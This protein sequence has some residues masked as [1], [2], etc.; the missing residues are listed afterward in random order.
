MKMLN[1]DK[2]ITGAVV[3]EL[4]LGGKSHPVHAMSVENFI[5]TSEA[6]DRVKDADLT[7]QVKET[8]KTIC[9]SVPSIDPAELGPLPIEKLQVVLAFVRGDE[10]EEIVG[11]GANGE[12]SGKE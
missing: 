2:V 5:M 9:R 4:V 12:A 6:I 8:I 1:L 10:P 7:E 11:E 3:R